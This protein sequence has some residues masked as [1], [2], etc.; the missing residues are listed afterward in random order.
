MDSFQPDKSTTGRTGDKSIAST[1]KELVSGLQSLLRGEIHLATAE[2]KSSVKEAG[3]N[4]AFTAVFAIF[5]ILGF[6]PWIAFLVIGL[7]LILGG[8]YWLSSLIVSVIHLIIGGVMAV[9]FGK[10]I[11][12]ENFR[13]PITR[14]SLKSEAQ[15]VKG[16]LQ[17]VKEAARPQTAN[18]V[19]QSSWQSTRQSTRHNIQRR[20]S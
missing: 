10:R 12:D 5:L 4:A 2:V 11:L 7:G 3:R 16:Q 6:L 9:R 14:Q 8:K 18:R 1:L 13:L 17:S 15:L 19:S 20:A